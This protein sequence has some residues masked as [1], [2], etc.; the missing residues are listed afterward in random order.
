MFKGGWKNL[1]LTPKP[2]GLKYH[3]T[4]T[5]HD[6]EILDPTVMPTT[7]KHLMVV[8]NRGARVSETKDAEAGEGGTFSFEER[9]SMLCTMYRDEQ[10][11]SFQYKK[12]KFVIKGAES[13]GGKH[14]S[15]CSCK[16]DLAKYAGA[17]DVERRVEMQFEGKGRQFARLAITVHSRWIKDAKPHAADAMSNVSFS[18]VSSANSGILDEEDDESSVCPSGADGAGEA[19]PTPPRGFPPGFDREPVVAGTAG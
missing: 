17:E 7:Y 8:W 5:V 2:G 18:V 4:V 13:S 1:R 9:L 10:T 6:V 11:G 16:I 19:S 3:F 14:Q 12:A 15:I